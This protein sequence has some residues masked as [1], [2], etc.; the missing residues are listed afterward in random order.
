[1]FQEVFLK[2]ENENIYSYAGPK[3]IGH[4]TKYFQKC[5]NGFNVK[6]ENFYSFIFENVIFRKYFTQNLYVS[7]I[8]ESG[9]K[10]KYKSIREK[11]QSL[12]EEKL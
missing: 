7:I 3:F 4:F 9:M 8:L 10:V 2:Y 1:M 12:T 11:L 5:L 6:F